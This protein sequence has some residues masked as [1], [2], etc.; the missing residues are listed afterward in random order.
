MKNGYFQIGCSNGG[1]IVKVVK[2]EDGG[3]FVSAKEIADYLTLHGILYD[4]GAITRG[5]QEA[6]VAAKNEFLFLVNKDLVPEIRESY[7]LNI[8]Q[9]RMMAVAKF[10][11]P[12]MKGQRMSADEF[13]HD[14]T[15]KGIIFGIQKEAIE[16]FF[17]TPSYCTEFV[18]AKGEEPRQGADARIE[19]FFETDLRA[20]PTLSEDGSVDF[21]HLN[22]IN[23]CKKDDILA[24]LYP[25][26]KGEDG[27][28]IYG[29]HIKPR[30][31]KRRSLKFGRNIKLSE[32]RCVITSEV[33]GHVML[34][35]DK[36]FVSNVLEVENV[37]TATGNIDYEGSVQVNGNVCTNFKISARGNVQV[38]GVVE[39]AEIEADGDIII[40]RG[41]NG[42]GK[43]VLKAGGNVVS[44]FIENSSVKAGGYVSTESILHS[45]VMAGTEINVTGKKGFITGGRVCATN[46]IHVKT[47]GS[48]MGAD[49]IVEIGVDPAVKVRMQELQKMVVEHK[50]SIDATH[51]VLTATLQ[52][53]QQG[54]K[55][56]P[57]QLKYFQEMLQEE[58]AKKQ[59]M[60]TALKEMERLQ[61]ILD[62]SAAAKVEVTGEVYSGTKICIADVSMI[63]K[64][65]MTYCKFIKSQGDVKMVAL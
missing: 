7:L 57:E 36:V 23:H 14:L 28:S 24:R 25:E 26:D 62:E 15:H 54:V 52:K 37:D 31:V 13:I 2:P 3:R 59:E 22:T 10:Y 11:P 42:M 56:K 63:V 58:N 64:N 12:S 1:T 61:V 18:V 44:K 32:D 38:R 55:M 34:V 50:K 46:L 16:N 53:I 49:T 51:P 8:S 9:D 6:A 40:E 30:E 41:M 48:P 21:F 60:E 19:Y 33:N 5:I 45:T 65:P 27:T 43:G 35:E 47:L 4:A 20:K 17:K 29:E 39:G